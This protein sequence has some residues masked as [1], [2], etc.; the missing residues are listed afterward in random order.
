MKKITSIFLLAFFALACSDNGSTSFGDNI[1][2]PAPDFTYTSLDGESITLSQQNGKVVYLFFFGANCSHCRANGPVT[3]TRIYQ[4]YNGNPD[5]VALG[6]DT[7]NTSA[8]AV[9]NFKSITGISY[10]LLLNAQKS[11]I[12]YY[13]DSGS[14]DRSVVIAADGTIAYQ[15][16]VFVNQDTDSVIDVIQ[17][18]LAKL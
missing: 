16:N 9:G 15:G 2:E 6:L 17:K 12:D 5:F 10:P 14:Y 7:W 4:E 3:E 1:G 8:S 13:G 18:E 11:L